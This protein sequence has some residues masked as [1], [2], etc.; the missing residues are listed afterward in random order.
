ML[1]WTSNL[2]YLIVFIVL[3][4]LRSIF[5]MRAESYRVAHYA[6]FVHI[7]HNLYLLI[8][9]GR[10]FMTVTTF[11]PLLAFTN[12]YSA[13]VDTPY[14]TTCFLIGASDLAALFLSFDL[15]VAKEAMI[16]DIMDLYELPQMRQPPP[17]P[18][19]D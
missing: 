8:M 5:C 15:C 1:G 3:I 13:Y 16:S 10:L 12:Y 4:C 7:K 11:V 2:T 18:R 14:Y 6:T 17:P 9:L 19:V